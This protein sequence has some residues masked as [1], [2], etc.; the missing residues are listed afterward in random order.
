M[1]TVINCTKIKTSKNFEDKVLK[2]FPKDMEDDIYID[3]VGMRRNRGLGGAYENYLE[4]FI[5]RFNRL[6]FT[7]THNDSVGWDEY[8]DWDENSKKYQDWAKSTVL[9]LLEQNKASILTSN[10]II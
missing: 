5:G 10:K 3:C 2:F 9:Y 6:S 7:D 8:Q 4:I 1:K